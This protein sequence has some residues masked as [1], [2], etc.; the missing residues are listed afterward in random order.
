MEGGGERRRA[1]GRGGEVRLSFWWSGRR[2]NDNWVWLSVWRGDRIEK[3]QR[4]WVW[5]IIELFC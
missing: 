4:R 2:E 3:E 1:G 5:E